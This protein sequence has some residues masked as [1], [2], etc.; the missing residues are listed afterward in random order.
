DYPAAKMQ[1]SIV[2]GITE[3][4]VLVGL[5]LLGALQ[6]IDTQLGNLIN[7][8]MLRQVALIGVVLALLGTC[9][10]PFSAWNKFRLEA[11][12]CFNRIP[13]RLFMIDAIKSLV[14]AL[15]LG[16]PLAA[17]VLWIMGNTGPDW[18]WWAWGIWVAFN[19]LIIWLFPTIIAP[20]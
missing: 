8:E 20:L 9:G 15:S 3:A 5:T 7:N 1:F 12:F 11:R 4:A 6:V 13:P 17:A 16:T 19:L 10:L 18:V 14:L 2:E